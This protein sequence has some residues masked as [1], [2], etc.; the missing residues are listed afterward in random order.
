MVTGPFLQR[1]AQN[2]E[3]GK[4][5]EQTYAEKQCGRNLIK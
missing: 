4:S 5:L 2:S 1:Q 3:N